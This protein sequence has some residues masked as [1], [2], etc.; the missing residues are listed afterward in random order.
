MFQVFAGVSFIVNPI[1]QSTSGVVIAVMV[2]FLCFGLI[3]LLLDLYNHY[4]RE[5]GWDEPVLSAPGSAE[6]VHDPEY[7]EPPATPLPRCPNCGEV[8]G[9]D[10]DRCPCG[11]KIPK[12][13]VEL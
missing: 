2:F 4:L 5:Y 7:T 1:T 3:N 8:L 13:Y 12:Q 6:V 9:Q 11:Y 10:W